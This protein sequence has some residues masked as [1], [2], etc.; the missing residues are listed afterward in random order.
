MI[1]VLHHDHDA[2][3]QKG[4]RLPLA[5][6]IAVCMSLALTVVSVVVYYTAGFYKFDLSRPGFESVRKD[7]VNTDTPKSYDTT[8]PVNSAA[9]DSFLGEYDANVNGMRA[10]GDFQDSTSLSD[11]AL[12]LA[13]GDTSN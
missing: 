3:P 10:Y 7:V 9:L 5:L 6:G 13:P 2:E 4:S 11:K 8:T 1:A 12:L